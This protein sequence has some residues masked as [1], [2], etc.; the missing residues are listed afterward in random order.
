M[1]QAA[2]LLVVRVPQGVRVH[3]Q[4]D[5]VCACNGPNP[6]HGVEQLT[7]ITHS[8]RGDIP[9]TVAVEGSPPVAV[10]VT[11]LRHV[12]SISSEVGT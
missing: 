7:T 1:A 8:Q 9:G 5:R 12:L 2:Y 10:S 6:V 4:V 11:S 3:V